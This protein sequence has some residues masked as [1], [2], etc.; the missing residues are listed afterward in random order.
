MAAARTVPTRS[1]VTPIHPD[2]GA[3]ERGRAGKLGPSCLLVRLLQGER[4][5]R[6]REPVAAREP[7]GRCGLVRVVHWVR[8]DTTRMWGSVRVAGVV[9]PVRGAMHHLAR[10]QGHNGE[11][12][13][14]LLWL[15]LPPTT[16]CI[17]Y[18]GRSLRRVVV[19][20]ADTAP[21]TLRVRPHL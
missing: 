5:G 11:G 7:R 9:I 13:P 12:P 3:V 4:E 16:V 2:R 15:M 6:D 17:H 1:R 18:A 19:A 21:A 20:V 10:R 8:V 14:A